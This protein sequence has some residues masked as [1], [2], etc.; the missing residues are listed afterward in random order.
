[1][2]LVLCPGLCS[3]K[4]PKRLIIGLDGVAYR[5]MRVLQ[6]GIDYRDS[7]GKTAHLQ[8][9]HRG[10][11]PVSILV[12][13]FPSVSDAAWTDIFADRPLRG[14]QR[15]YYSAAVNREIFENGVTTSMEYERQ[16]NWRVKGGWRHFMGYV[17]PLKSFAY[18]A[19]HLVDDFLNTQSPDENYYVLVSSTDAAQHLSGNILTMLCTLDQQIEALREIYRRR[20]GR[21]LEI[22]ILSDHGN[23]H[24]GAGKRVPIRAFLKKAGYRIVRSIHDPRDVVLPTAGIESWVEVHNAPSQT[25][26][27]MQTLSECEG[28]DVLSGRDPVNTNRFLVMRALGQRAVIEHDTAADSYRY[29]PESGD[30]IGYKPVLES[31]ASRGLLDANGFAPADVWMQETFTHRYPLAL[32]RIVRGHT[33]NALNPATILI[34]LDNRYVHASW[35]IKKGSEFVT[36]GG[37]HGALDDLNSNGILLSSF[38][39]TRDTSTGR[40]SGFYDGFA[41]L[42]DFRAGENGAEWIS[43]DGQAMTL[44]TRLPLDRHQALLS[45]GKVY[46]RV[47]TTNFMTDPSGG[48]LEICVREPHA[49]PAGQI[50]RSDPRPMP[51]LQKNVALSGPLVFPGGPAYEKVYEW[52]E[53]IKLAPEKTYILSGW[54]AQPT[55]SIPLFK[56]TFET[57]PHGRPVAY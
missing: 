9:F 21:E 27:L 39:P 28:V 25:E 57:D 2:G 54:I 15:T 6:E 14:Y 50:K 7:Q 19:R 12:S 49:G 42:Q 26:A 13:T 4:L 35:F 29:I 53:G 23:N 10:Y 16:M 5:D 43:L 40:V 48:S 30:P 32:E 44:S 37:T 3:A 18:E 8:A 24:A 33:R 31:L 52:P 55:K 22:L 20:E 38:A 47:W 51:A 11:Y 46:L 36:F 41:G 56:L 34:S 17:Y 45:P 1:L